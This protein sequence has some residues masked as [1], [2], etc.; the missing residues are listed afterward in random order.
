MLTRQDKKLLSHLQEN[1]RISIVELAKATD[2]SESTCLR[3]TKHLEESGVNKK[4][5]CFT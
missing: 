2:M 3:R 1:G 4:V 5:W